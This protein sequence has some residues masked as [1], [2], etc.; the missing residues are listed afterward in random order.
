M[1]TPEEEK[2]YFHLL[3][4]YRDVFAWSYREMPDLDPRLQSTIWP[5]G[6]VFGL[7]NNL[8]AFFVPN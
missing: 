1:L 6:R 2:K 5:S 4:E 7:K 8:R 3:F